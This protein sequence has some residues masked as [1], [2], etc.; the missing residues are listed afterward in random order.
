MIPLILI[1]SAHRPSHHR[2][3]HPPLL[4]TPSA[5]DPPPSS[6]TIEQVGQRVAAEELPEHV[7][8]IAERVVT[9][10]EV[11]VEARAAASRVVRAEVVVVVV[12]RGRARAAVPDAV[13]AVLVVGFPLLLCG[14]DGRGGVG[15]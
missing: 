8:G 10:E 11:V 7:V 4:A 1:R 14:R 13:L 9:K 2:A 12:G 15:C 6:L 3:G 5:A